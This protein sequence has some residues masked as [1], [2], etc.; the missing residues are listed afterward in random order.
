M[1]DILGLVSQKIPN[2]V[3]LDL[4]TEVVGFIVTLEDTMEVPHVD[5]DVKQQ[6]CHSWFLHCPL[7]LKGSYINVWNKEGKQGDLIFIP[8]GYFVLL[9]SDVVH[10]G[11][12]SGVEN[13]SLH[14]KLLAT[15]IT[16]EEK[17]VL[18]MTGQ[19][20]VKYVNEKNLNVCYDTAKPIFEDEKRMDNVNKVVNI[21]LNNHSFYKNKLEAVSEEQDMNM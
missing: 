7:I 16:N 4:Y 17:V 3:R 15:P 20:W 10:S 12:C 13:L 9:R 6:H 2:N 18:A 14:C 8:F 21:P 19:E 11:I 1:E 5:V